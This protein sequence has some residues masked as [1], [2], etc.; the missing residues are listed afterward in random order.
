MDF[1]K[2][3][4]RREASF[5]Q[6]PHLNIPTGPPMVTGFSYTNSGLSTVKCTSCGLEVDVASLK[7]TSPYALHV[8]RCP[9]CLFFYPDHRYRLESDRRQSFLY[10]IGHNG[11]PDVDD[12]VAAGFYV[13]DCDEDELRCVCCDLSLSSR[14][15]ATDIRQRHALLSPNCVFIKNAI[16]RDSNGGGQY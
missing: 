14:N 6:W 3:F 9:G 16:F 4:N 8:L 2:T 1:K 5:R 11:A 10:W 12:L 15:Q 7:G 13:T